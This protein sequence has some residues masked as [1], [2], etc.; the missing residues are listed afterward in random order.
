MFGMNTFS[1]V[2]AVAVASNVTATTAMV[3]VH[4]FHVG[5]ILAQILDWAQKRLA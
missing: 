3:V 5:C 2:C 1:V 4:I